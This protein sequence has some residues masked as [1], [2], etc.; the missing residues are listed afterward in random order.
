MS[1]AHKNEKSWIIKYWPQLLV[2]GVVM[3]SIGANLNNLEGII[4]QLAGVERE[5][6]HDVEYLNEEDDGVRSDFER[7]DQCDTKI[8]EKDNEI[9]YWKIKYEFCNNK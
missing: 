4:T 7:A 8:A 1:E 9:L 6:Q 5:H 2:F 3:L